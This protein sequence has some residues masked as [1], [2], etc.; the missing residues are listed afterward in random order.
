[1][2]NNRV[3][4]EL[5]AQEEK[6]TLHSAFKRD[7]MLACYTAGRWLLIEDPSWS[8]GSVYRTIEKKKL[9]EVV[10]DWNELDKKY[11]CAAVDATGYA[12]AYT[13]NKMLAGGTKWFPNEPMSGVSPLGAGFD[14]SDWKNSLIMRPVENKLR[15]WNLHEFKGAYISL[16]GQNVF[17]PAQINYREGTV[18]IPFHTPEWWLANGDAFS[19]D[20][21]VI[22][23]G[24]AE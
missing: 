16:K 5:L 21:L 1:M 4:Y 22:P 8:R 12:Y 18:G 14:A 7:G 24:E 23:C 10:G 20:G 13:C 17:A 9:S 19:S 11:V 2:N 15:P 6:E 3:S